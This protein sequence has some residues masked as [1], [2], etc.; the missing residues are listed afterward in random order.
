MRARV[1]NLTD[2]F[3]SLTIP[4]LCEALKAAFSR[5]YG[6]PAEDFPW[7]ERLTEAD[8]QARQSLREQF[9]SWEWTFG[10]QMPFDLEEQNRFPWGEAS[11]QIH[12]DRGRIR[13]CRCY[14]DAMDPLWTEGMTEALRD[15]R[16]AQEDI[17]A[18]FA[19]LPDGS[20]PGM[21]E[22]LKNMLLSM[23]ER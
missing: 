13:G 4:A 22:D 12:V 15:I 21:R 11:L 8:R 18:A 2:R 10:R 1:L 19:S 6:L 3:P 14:T 5:E 23:T 9:A 20:E 16:F 17:R 7:E